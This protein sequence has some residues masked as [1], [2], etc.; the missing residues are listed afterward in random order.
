MRLTR[1]R[2]LH[3]LAASAATACAGSD[4]SKGATRPGGAADTALPVDTGMPSEPG[5]A[6]AEALGAVFE[7]ALALLRADPAHR[8][9]RAVELVEDG[10]VEGIFALVRDQVVLQPGRTH[11]VADMPAAGADPTANGWGMLYGPR[12]TLRGGAGLARDKVELL[13]ALLQQAGESAE[14]VWVESSLTTTQA[15]AARSVQPAE[16]SVEVPAELVERWS[17]L[18]G[19]DLAQVEELPPP[20]DSAVDALAEQILALL[21]TPAAPGYVDGLD[22]TRL[23]MVRWS[24]ASG[25]RLLCPLLPE[26]T[27]DD[28]SVP[29]G[30]VEVA[31]PVQTPEVEVVLR[32]L[33]SG[34]EGSLELVR[35]TFTA[36]ELAGRQLIIGTQPI[37]SLDEL[38]GAEVGQQF[39]AHQ[40]YLAVQALDGDDVPEPVF[41]TVLTTAGGA[42]QVDSTGAVA[43]DGGPALPAEETGDP[44]SVVEV[45]VEVDARAFPRVV[46]RAWP[47]DEAGEL[48]PGL[49]RQSLV[50]TEEGLRHPVTLREVEGAL[51]VHLL[52]DLSSSM[53]SAYAVADSSGWIETVVAALEAARPGVRVS[54]ST[55]EVDQASQLAAQVADPGRSDLVLMVTDGETLEDVEAMAA[56]FAGGPPVFLADVRDTAPLFHTVAAE[57]S[58]GATAAVSEETLEDQLRAWVEAAPA[59]AYVLDYLAA[60]EPPGER[61]VVLE[62]GSAA[63]TATYAV[64]AEPA[65]SPSRLTG[66]VL[67]LQTMG[68]SQRR[69]LAG[70][71]E[72]LSPRHHTPALRQAAL[73]EIL[74]VLDGGLTLVA[75]GGTPGPLHALDD[76]F[77]TALAALPWV[78]E[79]SADID[80]VR[81]RFEAG[82]PMLPLGAVALA[83]GERPPADGGSHAHGL[84]FVLHLHH[85]DEAREQSRHQLDALRLHREHR[86]AS[87]DAFTETLRAT[88][89]R[90]LREAAIAP[91]DHTLA[92]LDGLTL[93]AVAPGERPA[94]TFDDELDAYWD[95]VVDAAPEGWLLVPE[96]LTVRAAFWVDAETGEL[97]ALIDH[98][99]GGSSSHADVIYLVRSY[100]ALAGK[101]A[102]CSP[103]LGVVSALMAVIAQYWAIATA[104]VASLSAPDTDRLNRLHKMAVCNIF[105]SALG[106]GNL[107]GPLNLLLSG[108]GIGYCNVVDAVLSADE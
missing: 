30:A 49:G 19:V 85:H 17:A 98:G 48:V 11:L 106:A 70:L 54:V 87:T 97:V 38:L 22:G 20:D 55:F 36:A 67:E 72:G 2:L 27:L 16:Q 29:V 42:V 73:A 5:T 102:A 91:D 99:A 10:D 43:I 101:L 76:V 103:G 8:V 100:V 61:E 44:G 57:A 107:A 31:E 68:R 53:P 80:E 35:G 28:P 108:L 65:G 105:A 45:D 81:D 59:G 13:A 74:A 7:E 63:G 71:P 14:V 37:A 84:R 96:D 94:F 52:W 60:A 33:R 95:E 93:T 66:L 23:P 51:R 92:R 6:P 86:S 26:A 79:N 41:G 64:P 90:A 58:G 21:P 62:V 4:G 89:R 104:C 77:Q 1:R 46:L 88:A 32:A 25:E 9:Q 82:L 40:P 75:E 3:L 69:L 18:A 78:A 50:V 83:D 12:G 47:R 15:A 56:L 24:G 34:D 39:A